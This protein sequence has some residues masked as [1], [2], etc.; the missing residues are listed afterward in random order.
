MRELDQEQQKVRIG[1]DRF[2]PYESMGFV[3]KEYKIFVYE[4]SKEV[5][6]YFTVIRGCPFYRQKKVDLFIQ[7][8]HIVDF[9]E[10]NDDKRF[11]ERDFTTVR[12][13]GSRRYF[14]RTRGRLR[15]PVTPPQNE[16]VLLS[17]SLC[18]Q[19]S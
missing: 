9:S 10:T 16:T 8:G 1:Q 4:N 18:L 15:R 17:G 11:T 5:Y 13:V 7:G 2:D 12:P 14:G 6:N 19:Y 3:P